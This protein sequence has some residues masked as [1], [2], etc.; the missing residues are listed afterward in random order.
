MFCTWISSIAALVYELCLS[1]VHEKKK[2][3]NKNGFIGRFFSHF[4]RTRRYV[5]RY[6]SDGLSCVSLSVALVAVWQAFKPCQAIAN[7]AKSQFPGPSLNRER[8]RSLI[9]NRVCGVV[10][11]WPGKHLASRLAEKRD[12]PYS[13]TMNWL[14]YLLFFCLLRSAVQCI[15]GLRSSIGWA[16]GPQIPCDI[17]S[18]EALVTNSL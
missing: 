16:I 7:L 17:I 3:E 14:R 11:S 10:F 1:K 8:S 13:C 6:Y 4:P 15:R 2:K 9:E 5:W 12:Q 18:R